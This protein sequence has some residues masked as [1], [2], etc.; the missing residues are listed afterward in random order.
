[1][2]DRLWEVARTLP[3]PLEGAQIIHLG[4]SI[5]IAQYRIGRESWD[6]LLKRADKALYASKNNG[7]DQWT[8]ANDNDRGTISSRSTPKPKKNQD[9]PE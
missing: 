9:E 4:I 5:G 6:D 3:I 2:A 1:M 7:R 8:I